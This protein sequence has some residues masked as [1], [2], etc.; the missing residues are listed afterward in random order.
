MDITSLSK[1]NNDESIQSMLDACLTLHERLDLWFAFT[2]RAI[3]LDHFADFNNV[4]LDNT[5]IKDEVYI[6]PPQVQTLLNNV[7]RFDAFYSP[8]K[9]SYGH[10]L[11]LFMGEHD[12]LFNSYLSH[13]KE[14]N[15]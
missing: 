13:Q 10:E 5:F 2:V 8:P 3:C 12:D 14:F 15:T 11:D 9:M 1:L 7:H 4:E 6:Y